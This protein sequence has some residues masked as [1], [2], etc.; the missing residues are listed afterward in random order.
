MIKNILIL[1]LLFCT[2]ISY[3]QQCP[4]VFIEAQYKKKYYPEGN[5]LSREYISIGMYKDALVEADKFD[6]WQYDNIVHYDSSIIA[7]N[8]YPYIYKALKE[9]DIVILNERHDY[10][11]HRA[12]LYSII[13]SFKIF[14]IKSIFIEA[15]GYKLDDSIYRQKDS[16]IIPGILTKE[17]IYNQTLRKANRLNLNVYS[18]EMSNETLDTL[19][20]SHKK[21]IIDKKND[22]WLPV[23][24]DSFLLSQFLSLDDYTQRDCLQALHIY[25]K[26]RINKIQKAFIYCGYSHEFK[27]AGFMAGIL[28][29]LLNKKIYVIDQ[30][31]LTEHSQTKYENRIYKKYAN[32][33]YP[34]VLLDRGRKPFHTIYANQNGKAS[35]N[36]IDMIIG[37]Q[38]TIYK[39]N[40]PNWLELNGDRRRYSL[41]KFIDTNTYKTNFLVT[42]YELNMHKNLKGEVVPTDI[43][44]VQFN[45]ADYDTILAPNKQYHF[46][47]WRNGIIIIDKII[48][49]NE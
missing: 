34:F 29:H 48:N 10:P 36:Y 19:T 25:Q 21:Y 38:K 12:L 4:K 31:F 33:N 9:N 16:E 42:I 41:S 18:Y 7:E 8:A 3:A 43:F 44:Q 45:A 5:E 26:I 27:S 28:Q 35:E 40:R 6:Q 46:I 32:I 11:L 15:L 17:N 14:G 47:A 20:V 22:K 37:S 30:S 23:E 24:A 13:D 1:F 39:K 2:C 49:T